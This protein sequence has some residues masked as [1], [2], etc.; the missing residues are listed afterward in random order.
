MPSDGQ[1]W[2]GAI[3]IQELQLRQQ[4]SPHTGSRSGGEDLQTCRVVIVDAMPSLAGGIRAILER[5][6]LSLLLLEPKWLEPT[7]LLL[8]LTLF[9]L[10]LLLQL[11]SRVA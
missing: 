2:W 10:L 1:A 8:L 4:V 5:A 9:L 3:Q 7:W 11:V 6:I